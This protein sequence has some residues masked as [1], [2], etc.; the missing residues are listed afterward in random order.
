MDPSGTDDS[1]LQVSRLGPM[2]R[3]P[4]KQA[5]DAGPGQPGRAAA[6]LEDG[7]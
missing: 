7:G 3:I 2:D 4:G 1:E 5:K 6:V